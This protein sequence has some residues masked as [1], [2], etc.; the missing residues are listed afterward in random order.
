MKLAFRLL[1]ALLALFILAPILVVVVSSF[2][3]G[4]IPE[5]PPS[6]WSLRWYGHALSQS[7]FVDSAINSVWL[8]LM[9]TAIATPLALAAAVALV[10][11][12]FPGRNLIQTLLLA[13]LFVPAIISSLA[14]LVTMANFGIRGV[15]LRLVAAHVLITF[16]YLV[17]TIMA[18]LTRLDPL[19]EEAARTLGASPAR[20]FWHVTLP[21]VRSGVYAGMLFALIV[22]FDNVSMSL[23]LTTARTN[24]LPLA[25]MNYVEYNFDPSIAAISTLLVAIS[26]GTAV[27][28]ERAVGLRSV[29]GS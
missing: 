22:S 8:A 15:T 7:I 28:L 1:I 5:F 6:N 18:S 3:G 9:A 2:S 17:R 19:V 16:P 14:I 21:L 24:T 27:L 29:V 26:L 12:R 13:P 23:F 20:T 25:I 11:C 10:R 4:E